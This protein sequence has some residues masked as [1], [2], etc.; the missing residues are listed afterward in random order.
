MNTYN[1]PVRWMVSWFDKR[2]EA[3]V[4]EVELAVT[5]EMDL[6]HRLRIDPDELLVGEWEV[7]EG[8]RQAV[9]AMAGLTLDFTRFDY[10][11]GAVAA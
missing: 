8:D 11:F 7:R 5:D 4:G 6:K 1:G 3:F 9:E 2:T 10:F